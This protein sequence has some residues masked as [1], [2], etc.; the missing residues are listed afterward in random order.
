MLTSYIAYVPTNK[1]ELCNIFNIDKLLEEIITFEEFQKMF[2]PSISSNSIEITESLEYYKKNKQNLIFENSYKKFINL[3][4]QTKFREKYGN[5]FE[6]RTN[7]FNEYINDCK[8]QYPINEFI[9][10]QTK[11]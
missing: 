1:N 7:I 10:N 2:N 5:N 3:K 8:A 6:G 9:K 11:N 4:A